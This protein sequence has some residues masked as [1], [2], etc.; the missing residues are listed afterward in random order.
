MPPP[1]SR[2]LADG[3]LALDYGRLLVQLRRR[4]AAVPVL[5]T[6]RSILAGLGAAGLAG[7][8]DRA[9][10]AAGVPGP[11]LP[12]TAPRDGQQGQEPP[13]EPRLSALTGREQAV[14]RL[15]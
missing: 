9:L 7:E 11:E 13:R 5:L 6:G 2:S 15:A 3:L 1:G 8:C 10:L 4:K 14:A 12:G